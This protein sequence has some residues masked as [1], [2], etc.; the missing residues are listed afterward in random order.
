MSQGSTSSFPA[1]KTGG[2]PR[3]VPADSV[4]AQLNRILQSHEFRA[5]RRSQEFLKYVVESTLNG[6]ADLLKERTIGIDVF[7][8]PA[9]YD[10]SDDATVRVKAGEVRKRLGLYY[11]SEGRNDDLRIELPAG[12]Y[13][14]DFRWAEH[15]PAVVVEEHAP[16]PVAAP[17]A[18][19]RPS[20]RSTYI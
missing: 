8:R 2:L 18:P 4:Y 11:A 16:P 5:S 12:T 1:G 20:R 13:V 19:A 7:G 3:E 6:H 14:P 15:Q 9:S 10:P 17:A